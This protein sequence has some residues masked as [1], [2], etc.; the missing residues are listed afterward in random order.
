[1][2]ICDSSDLSVDEV[3]V[4]SI[5]LEVDHSE[6]HDEGGK[7]VG[8]VRCVLSVE[9]IVERPSFVLSSQHEMEKRDEGA[10]ELSASVKLDGDGGKCFPNDVL[11][12]VSSNEQ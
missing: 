4:Y 7:E 5:T 2:N 10:F 8:H 9:R 12:N 6:G 1:M 11:S 3:N